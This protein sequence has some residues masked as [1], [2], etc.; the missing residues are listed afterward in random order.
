MEAIG[1]DQ[2]VLIIQMQNLQIG[3]DHQITTVVLPPLLISAMFPLGKE[4]VHSI[5]VLVR[6][7]IHHALKMYVMIEAVPAAHGHQGMI[8]VGVADLIG[9]HLVSARTWS[10]EVKSASVFIFIIL[11]IN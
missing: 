4:I 8:K 5:R 7:P 2:M 1:R 3:Q 10:H 11:L 9:T 6:L